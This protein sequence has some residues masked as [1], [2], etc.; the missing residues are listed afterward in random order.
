MTSAMDKSANNFHQRWR[1]FKDSLARYAV[2]AGGLGVIVAIVSNLF[3][4]ALC[5]VSAVFIGNGRIGQ[6]L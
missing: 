5:C 1:L 6:S 4:F 2:V 3:L